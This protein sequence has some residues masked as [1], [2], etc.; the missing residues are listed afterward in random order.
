MSHSPCRLVLN[1]KI[2]VLVLCIGVCFLLVYLVD[3]LCVFPGWR[4]GQ[5][6]QLGNG[7][8]FRWCP[9]GNFIMGAT[10]VKSRTYQDVDPAEVS[11]SGFWLQETEVTQE[12]WRRVML[13][14]PWKGKMC[15]NE[16][17]NCP[18]S[19]IDYANARAFAEKMTDQERTA[20]RLPKGWKYELPTEAQWEYGCRAGSTTRFSFGDD[21]SQLEYYGWYY[22]NAKHMPQPVGQLAA[23]RWGLRDMHGNLQEWC[24]DGYIDHLTGG[25]NPI[26]DLSSLNVA[27]R[28][29]SHATDYIESF[30][31]SDRASGVRGNSSHSLGFRIAVIRTVEGA[32]R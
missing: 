19:Y 20:G 23:N 32:G 5:R 21:P 10:Q 7:M 27:V 9:D 31:C 8:T 3:Q 6:K 25:Q 13:T 11:L 17:P 4:Q 14:E 24:F 22:K 30:G 1:R 2:T 12:Q 16:S 26:G 15:V 29:G 28:G 18:A